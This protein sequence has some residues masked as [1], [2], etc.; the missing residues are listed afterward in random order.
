MFWQ[1]PPSAVEHILVEVAD[2]IWP[3]LHVTFVTG[4]IVNIT[5]DNPNPKGWFSDDT[6]ISLR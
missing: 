2:T 6:D 1:E 3:T 5:E 4:I